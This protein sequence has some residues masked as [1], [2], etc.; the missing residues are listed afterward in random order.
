MKNVIWLL[1]KRAEEDQTAMA[2]MKAW[3]SNCAREHGVESRS[4]T[5]GDDCF[6][7]IRQGMRKRRVRSKRQSEVTRSPKP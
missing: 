6:L 1:K 5:F 2:F 4:I 3:A 7:V